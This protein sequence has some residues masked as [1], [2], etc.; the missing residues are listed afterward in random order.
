[1]LPHVLVHELSLR[2]EN[3]GSWPADTFGREHRRLVQVAL[4]PRPEKECQGK[5]GKRGLRTRV[6]AKPSA[7]IFE[8][9]FAIW[10]LN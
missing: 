10:M 3:Q 1:M 4:C 6:S 9:A 5:A 2:V 7:K 8:V